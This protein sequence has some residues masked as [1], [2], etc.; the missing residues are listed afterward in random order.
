MP[1]KTGARHQ[2]F[3]IST[4]GAAPLYMGF[5]MYEFTCPLPPA[6]FMLSVPGR[7][8]H[9]QSKIFFLYFFQ[10]RN[11]RD[12][13]KEKRSKRSAG[14][15][16]RDLAHFSVYYLSPSKSQVWGW[17]LGVEWALGHSLWPPGVPRL[18]LCGPEAQSQR[19]TSGPQA[20]PQRL[21]EENLLG[22]AQDFVFFPKISL[23]ILM[24]SPGQEP[25]EWLSQGEM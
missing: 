18:G 20:L 13:C 1:S 10:I 5:G 8:G 16:G 3:P 11:N 17:G 22:G 24:Y 2:K 14:Q 25:L 12:V 23:A 15:T 19:Q 21:L 4:Q 9:L 6:N 7:G